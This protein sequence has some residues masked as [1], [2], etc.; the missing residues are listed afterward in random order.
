MR[1]YWHNLQDSERR[2]VLLGA[3]VLALAVVYLLFSQRLDERGALQQR[4]AELL[5]QEQWWQEQADLLARLDNACS[6]AQLLQRE[7]EALLR[8]LAQRAQVDIVQLTAS[9]NRYALDLRGEGNAVLQ[10]AQQSMCQGLALESISLALIAGMEAGVE[11]GMENSA[12][13]NAAAGRGGNAQ[14]QARLE[15][16]RDG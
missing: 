7:P 4:K 13:E 8:L 9:G 2:T 11:A 15:L 6:G 16:R 14:V 5:A 3:A 10:L 12:G 1:Q